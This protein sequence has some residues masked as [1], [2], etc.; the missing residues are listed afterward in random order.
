MGGQGY[1]P[2]LNA[3]QKNTS[4]ADGVDFSICTNASAN[5]QTI[6]E[7][8]TVLGG[9][10]AG[11]ATRVGIGCNTPS[12]TLDVAGITNIGPASGG[13]IYAGT[14]N[15]L[16]VQGS[17]NGHGYIRADISTTSSDKILYLGTGQSNNVEINRTNVVF[18]VSNVV[19]VYGNLAASGTSYLKDISNTNVYATGGLFSGTTAGRLVM[20]GVQNACYIEAGV[21]S[22]TGSA[23]PLYFTDMNNSNQWMCIGSTGNIGM[24]TNAP[25][26]KLDVV[27]SVRWAQGS[28]DT[29]QL[30]STSNGNYNFGAQNVYDPAAYGI[31]QVT[32][33]LANNGGVG[34][35]EGQWAYTMVQSGTRVNGIGMMP[36]VGKIVIGSGSSVT[37]GTSNGLTIDVQNGR[38]DQ[39]T[40]F[41][42]GIRILQSVNCA[43]RGQDVRSVYELRAISYATTYTTD[44]YFE[45]GYNTGVALVNIAQDN[46]NYI[47]ITL[48]FNGSHTYTG[49][50]S[51]F[52][53][54]LGIAGFSTGFKITNLTAGSG[55]RGSILSLG[56]SSSA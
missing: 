41:A 8:L 40:G 27:G 17:S 35:A 31:V 5:I 43:M 2:W 21:N 24:G 56:S 32:H 51:G 54:N 46:G 13:T 25:G 12:Y 3:Y 37:V 19:Q 20:V 26:T 50:G 42:S 55:T 52:Q 10:N 23:A 4:Y 45:C 47:S 49:A 29:Y 44:T 28:G 18:N 30:F 7:R 34:A 22:D 1:G 48:Y 9:A 11:G 14:S 53:G 16:V 39:T 36:N 6:T 33:Q 38:L 15:G